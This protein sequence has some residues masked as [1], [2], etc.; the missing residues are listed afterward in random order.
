MNAGRPA[1]AKSDVETVMFPA[2]GE[3]SEM[4]REWIAD[5]PDYDVESTR[6]SSHLPK[7]F[8]S[9]IFVKKGTRK[10]VKGLASGRR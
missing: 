4:I 7:P 1:K 9:A 6:D 2:K 5:N 3:I 10:V 8:R